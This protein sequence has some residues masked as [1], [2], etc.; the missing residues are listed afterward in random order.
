MKILKNNKLTKLLIIILLVILVGLESATFAKYV[1]EKVSD[2]FVTSKNFYFNSNILK[3]DNPHYKINNWSGL[4]E[5][6]ISFD[7]TSKNNNYVYTDYDISYETS[8][9][10]PDDVICSIDKPNGTIYATT[11][12]DNVVVTVVPTR[13]YTEGE[14][15]DIELAATSKEPYTK[16][17]S[18]VF[19][20]IVGKSGATFE[21]NDTRNR[22]YLLLNVTNAINNCTIIEAFDT[23]KKGDILDSSKYL[24]L[25]AQNKEKC[26]SQ[27][28]TVEFD[29]NTILLD[30]VGEIINKSNYSTT[31]IN[32]IKYINKLEYYIGPASTIDVKF[33][34]ND[35]TI[36]YAYETLLANNI[37]K[38]EINDIE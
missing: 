33:Y 24:S 25:S 11:H 30:T 21:I 29:P 23:Y 38:V 4:G 14:K 31:E 18:A 26:A 17:I 2:Y 8:V 32:G 6:T 16:K 7:L 19:E 27:K 36:K 3:E 37:M 1:I 20:Y 9:K 10:C 28:I 12:I 13:L 35:A 22:P 5:F 34:K 15:I